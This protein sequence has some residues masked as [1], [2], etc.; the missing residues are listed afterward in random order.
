[1]V[2]KLTLQG[3]LMDLNIAIIGANGAIGQAMITEL[4]QKHPKAQIHAFARQPPENQRPNVTHH[5][6]DYSD[7]ES[8][9]EAANVAANKAPLDFVFVATGILHDDTTQPEKSFKALSAKNMQHLYMIDTIVPSLIAKH[10]LP[11]LGKK[12]R[13]V[14]AALSA[15]V[16]SISD[17]RL[18][19]WYSYRAAK[20]ALNMVIKCAAIEIK[21]SHKNAI[22]VGLHPGT[23]DSKLSAPFQSNVPDGKLFSKEHAANQLLSVIS[24]LK[25]TDS[26]NCFAW[27][28]S[29]IEP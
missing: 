17:N 24:S 27:D 22:I 23:V 11:K 5:T 29:Q 15:R 7:E 14:F 19:G 9:A 13:A 26:G 8:I 3:M 6:I 21:R 18:G 4:T 25:E 2:Y 28:G 16:G 10:F 1:M 12:Q 20:A